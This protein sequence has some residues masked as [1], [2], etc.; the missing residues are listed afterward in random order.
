[1]TRSRK[2]A[3]LVGSLRKDSFSRKIAHAIAA[4]APEG[5]EFEEV[6]VHA[7]FYD[8]DLETDTP[9]AEWTAMREKVGAADA[10]LILTP[11]Y[12]RSTSGV[13]KNAIDILSRPLG[14]SVL[15]RKPAA[16]VSSSPGAIGGFGAHHH[17]R[18]MLTPLGATLL[19]GQ[20]MYLSGVGDWFEGEKLI[21]NDKREYLA[22]FAQEFAD[23][24][25]IHADRDVKI[26]EAA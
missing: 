18:Q 25:E 11:E 6:G 13:M 8:P 20:E 21:K 7:P 2:I 16:V 22:K 5:Y 24:I 1:M 4:V 23:W 19:T 3:V 10:V 17:V 14:K 15:T 26:S 9:P 12:N